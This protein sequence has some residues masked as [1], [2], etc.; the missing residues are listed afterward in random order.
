MATIGVKLPL[1]Y[2]SAD[3]FTMIKTLRGMIKQNLK[4]LVLTNP[5]ERVMEPNFGVGAMRALFANYSEGVEV[6]L[7]ERI[8]AQ[9][10]MY[11]PTVRIVRVVFQSEPDSNM[12]KMQI[13]YSIPSLGTNDL[14]NI[15]I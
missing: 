9:A 2:D 10:K 12:L 13:V 5:G 7:E 14:L 15:T 6:E 4:M 3:G 8:R 11:I 1:T